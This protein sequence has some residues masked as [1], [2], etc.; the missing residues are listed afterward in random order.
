MGPKS[1]VGN[2]SQ[3][4]HKQMEYSTSQLE[5]VKLETRGTDDRV[6]LIT[7]NRW[8]NNLYLDLP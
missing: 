3:Y 6:A 8:K 7:L 4:P 2:N 1:I 5:Y